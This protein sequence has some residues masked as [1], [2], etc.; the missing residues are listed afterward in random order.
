MDPCRTTFPRRGAFAILALALLLIQPDQALG[1]SDNLTPSSLHSCWEYE[2]I[3][4]FPQAQYT[5]KFNTCLVLVGSMKIDLRANSHEAW[6]ELTGNE[7]CPFQTLAHSNSVN[8]ST[9][10]TFHWTCAGKGEVEGHAKF[11]RSGLVQFLKNDAGYAIDNRIHLKTSLLDHEWVLEQ[12][13]T[14]SSGPMGSPPPSSVGGSASYSQHGAQVQIGWGSQPRPL[15][16][17]DSLD[18]PALSLWEGAAC[19]TKYDRQIRTRS[20][21]SGWVDGSPFF[22]AQ[23]AIQINSTLGSSFHLLPCPENEE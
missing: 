4:F 21:L 2:P 8:F 11:A 12:A 3:P 9:E 15:A 18:A 14:A 23:L 22:P 10:Y 6:G 5:E 1:S 7:A 16:F 17:A 20:K 13:A 19:L